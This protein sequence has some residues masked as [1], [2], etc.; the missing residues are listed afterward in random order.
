M[1]APKTSRGPR[2]AH[3]GQSNGLVRA[4][5]STDTA[6]DSIESRRV[7]QV[8]ATLVFPDFHRRELPILPD[9][10]HR[11][12]IQIVLPSPYGGLRDLS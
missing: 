10:S 1:V 8:H 2:Q 4:W 5:D 9:M 12:I 11:T 3:L 7:L 6:P